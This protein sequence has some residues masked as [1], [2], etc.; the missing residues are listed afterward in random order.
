MLPAPLQAYK[1]SR[2]TLRRPSVLELISTTGT[3]ESLAAMRAT[4]I[5]AIRAGEINAE[6]KTIARWNEAIWVRVLELMALQP[7]LA[8]AI[9]QTVAPWPKPE[10]LTVALAAQLD[11]VTAPRPA[12]KSEG[13]TG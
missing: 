1:A 13:V 5:E 11:L 4:L 10:G 7:T 8:M 6:V 2:G 9:Y 12:A 3:I